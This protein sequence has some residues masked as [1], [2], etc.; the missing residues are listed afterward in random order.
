MDLRKRKHSVQRFIYN[1]SGACDIHSDELN[2]LLAE[3]QAVRKFDVCPVKEEFI[4]IFNTKAC[5]IYPDK[6]C[7]FGICYLKFVPARRDLTS[8]M[9]LS[10]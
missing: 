6:I 5:C 10:R 1:A 8:S 4:R 2:R 3:E 7:A 9:L